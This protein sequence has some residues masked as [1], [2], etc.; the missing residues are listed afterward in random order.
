IYV[1]PDEQDNVETI[2]MSGVRKTYQSQVFSSLFRSEQNSNG[3]RVTYRKIYPA[4]T[5]KGS[6][7]EVPYEKAKENQKRCL[8]SAKHL[9]SGLMLAHKLDDIDVKFLS[10]N[11]YLD[12]EEISEELNGLAP[13]PPTKDNL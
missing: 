5:I 2:E 6:R 4:A 7:L 3:E 8:A 13:F 1:S 12:M 10:G 9:I 11:K